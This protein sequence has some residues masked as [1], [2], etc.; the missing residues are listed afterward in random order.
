MDNDFP[1]ECGR[2]DWS[3]C[4]GEVVIRALQVAY[5]IPAFCDKHWAEITRGR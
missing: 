3:P 5:E 1:L 2:D 4:E